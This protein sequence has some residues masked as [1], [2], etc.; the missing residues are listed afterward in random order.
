[1]NETIKLILSLSLSASILAV[2]LFAIKEQ[3]IKVDSIL[4]LDR[5][6]PKIG[7]AVYF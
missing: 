6:T 5:S 2:S 3:V 1:M 7:T 4:H